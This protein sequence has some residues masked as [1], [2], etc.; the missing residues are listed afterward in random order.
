MRFL[1]SIFFTA[2]LTLVLCASSAPAQTP[3]PVGT[4]SGQITDN[5]GNAIANATVTLVGDQTGT[6][7]THSDASGNYSIGYYS[8]HS[9]RVTP[10]KPFY[11]FDPASVGFVSSRPLSGDIPLSFKGTQTPFIV[12]SFPVLMTEENSLRALALDSVTQMRDPF[13]IIT[14]HNFSSDQRTRITLFAV[15][16][17]LNQ[18]ESLSNVTAQAEDSL[19]QTYNLPV[20]SVRRV[21]GQD[22]LSQVVV[23][24]PDGISNAVEV[25]VTIKVR[26]SGSNKVLIKVKPS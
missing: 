21:P 10:N 3:Q 23:K 19:H 12:F 2:I 17:E 20:E 6:Q 15:G 1:S 5:S 18:G 26:G 9:I 8:N 4:I 14:S 11:V 7:V 24:L 16:A 13:P 25:W 22:W